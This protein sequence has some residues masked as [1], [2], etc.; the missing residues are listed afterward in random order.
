MAKK[1]KKESETPV[2]KDVPIYN[3]VEE[4]LV[5]FGNYVNQKRH[6]PHLLGGLKPS[7]RKMLWTG[8]TFPDKNVKVATLAGECGGKYSPHAPETLPAV[9]SEMVHAGIFSGQGAHGSRSIYK[10][11][12]IG[13]AAGRYIEAKVAKEWREAISPLLTL[14]PKVKSDLGYLEPEY[15]PSPVPMSLLFG[16]LGLGIGVKSTIPFFSAKSMLKALET[17]NP[18]LLKANGDLVINKTKSEL[19]KLWDTGEGRVGYMFY[20]DENAIS[21]DGVTKGFAMYGDPRFLQTNLTP[22]LEGKKT[23]NPE[24]LG[25]IDKGLVTMVDESSRENG[26][27]IFFSVKSNQ[28]GKDKV[29]L[30]MLRKELEIM[31]YQQDSYK[32]A[33][34]N[35]QYTKVT[36]LREWIKACYDNYCDLVE[37]YKTHRLKAL[38][39]KKDVATHAKDIVDLIRKNDK[40]TKD[41]IAKQLK[42]DMEIVEECLKKSISVLMKLNKD[43][44]L[45]EIAKEEVKIKKLKPQD[46]YEGILRL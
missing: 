30:K 1:I 26:K 12:N 19:Q 14:V 8:L 33:I 42:L 21:E 25:W 11:W 43:K 13:S 18:N 22:K 16:S 9:V 31:R 20:I 5:E 39:L 44:E 29:T 34:S 2:I 4:G 41:K 23:G 6:M 46:F 17:N 37:Q 7:Y 3:L 45:A 40:V 24:D 27:R 36:P 28:R 32:I 38:Q 15:I 10:E 35:G